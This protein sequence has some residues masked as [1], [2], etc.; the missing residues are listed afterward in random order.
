MPSSLP[1]IVKC[2]API[3]ICDLGGWTDTW[4]AQQGRI[5]NIAVS[6]FVEVTVSACKRQSGASQVTV[7]AENYRDSYDLPETPGDWSKH[8]LIEAA[9]R[10]FSFPEDLHL[11]V[12]IYSEAPA[13][14]SVGTSASVS[15]AII[16]AL[17]EILGKSLTSYEIARKA[18]YLETEVLGLQS[19]IQDQLA[20]AY[21]G[22]NFIEMENYPRASVSPLLL[23]RETL[24]DLESR[25][26]LIYLGR[27]HSSSKVHDSVI[28]RLEDSP[29]FREKL[30]PLRHCALEG[31]K[32]L[33]A[34]DLSSFGRIMIEN[35]GAQEDLHPGL[36]G[37]RARKVIEAARQFGVDGY[38]VNGAG[39]EGGSVTVLLRAGMNSK[40]HFSSMIREL[41]SE[42]KPIPIRLAP[43]GLC[44]WCA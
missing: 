12:S 33:L 25:L 30:G 38:K 40:H 20:S 42:L 23:P 3:R 7:F 41:D 27:P 11:D 22:I 8:P 34:G 18:H 29:R 10:A 32:A 21:G 16:G 37:E 1:L 14:A 35:T 28:K 15:A 44:R 26:M 5:L 9:C 43:Q 19:G 6:P 31:K 17:D 2:T 36:V 4:F 24:W 13:G 39:G